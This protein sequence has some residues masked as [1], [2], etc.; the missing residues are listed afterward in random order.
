MLQGPL[1]AY[2]GPNML[3]SLICYQ[4]YRDTLNH[5][6]L[7]NQIFQSQ[8]EC[9]YLSCQIW[10]WLWQKYSILIWLTRTKSSKSISDKSKLCH[11]FLYLSD[12][13]W[14]LTLSVGQAPLCPSAGLYGTK[15]LINRICHSQDRG[16]EKN[17]SN[18][19]CC[20]CII[21]MFIGFLFSKW[22]RDHLPTAAP[23]SSPLISCETNRRTNQSSLTPPI[24]SKIH[25]HLLAQL[26]NTTIS[27]SENV[28]FL[29]TNYWVQ[30]SKWS[31]SLGPLWSWS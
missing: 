22:Q 24:K 3:P 21:T 26:Q 5:M 7:L 25:L 23:Q 6:Q 10:S 9:H 14:T 11:C 30:G 1:T 8:D 29:S 17:Q 13:R 12:C 31:L 20:I 16:G 27:A 19:V 15:A 4:S 28:S 18:P 2:Q